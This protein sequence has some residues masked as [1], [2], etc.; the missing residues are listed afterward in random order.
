[1]AML[2]R[3]LRRDPA[4]KVLILSMYD[5]EVIAAKT[6]EAGARGFVSKGADPARILEAVRRVAAGEMFIENRIA[7]KI[8]VQRAGKSTGLNALTQREFEVFHLLANGKDV[9]TIAVDLH[10]S[11]K[12]VGTH[13]THIMEKL[14]CR[15]VAQ[16]TRLAIRH[17]IIQP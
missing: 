13:R 6:L 11:P 5:D 16:L 17:G 4:A 9:R 8:A 1:L 3:L 15:N 14:G 12:T 7:Q 2:H 10:L